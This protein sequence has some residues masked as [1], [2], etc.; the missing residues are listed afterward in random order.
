MDIFKKLFGIEKS[1]IKPQ[2]I[3]TP[4]DEVGLF[5]GSQPAGRTRGD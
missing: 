5:A 3:L 1:R 2:C 4:L